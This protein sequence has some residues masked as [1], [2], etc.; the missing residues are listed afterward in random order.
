MHQLVL[1]MFAALEE[2]GVEGV[3]RALSRDEQ[4]LFAELC[5]S[6]QLTCWTKAF[7]LTV[8]RKLVAFVAAGQHDEMLRFSVEGL[9]TVMDGLFS[10]L[11]NG[12]ALRLDDLALDIYNQ[13]CIE[14]D[15][16]GGGGF[17]P[18]N[19]IGQAYSAFLRRRSG[20]SWG[21]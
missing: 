18:V 2:G 14:L 11:P 12:I 10:R 16:C 20:A 1:K 7:V 21:R 6:A 3:T 5:G 17:L 19:L 13:A 9:L 4:R 8:A 15:Q